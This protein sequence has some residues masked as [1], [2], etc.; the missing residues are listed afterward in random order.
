MKKNHIKIKSNL[1][2]YCITNLFER[3]IPPLK[4]GL[5]LPRVHTYFQMEFSFLHITTC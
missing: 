5:E 1:M 2:A 3:L 4:R